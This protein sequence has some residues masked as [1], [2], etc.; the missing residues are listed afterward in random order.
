M[1]LLVHVAVTAIFG[2]VAFARFS[3]AAATNP[4]VVRARTPLLTLIPGLVAAF[5]N[6]L[7]V[8]IASVGVGAAGGKSF[9]NGKTGAGPGVGAVAFIFALISVAANVAS[10]VLAAPGTPWQEV[11]LGPRKNPIVTISPMRDIVAIEPHAAPVHA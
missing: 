7:A 8:I 3:P 6:F 11:I 1:A 5:C 9:T 4:L 10:H 2:V